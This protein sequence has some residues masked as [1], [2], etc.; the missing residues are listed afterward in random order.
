MAKQLIT[1]FLL[2]CSWVTPAQAQNESVIEIGKNLK[3]GMPLKDTIALLGIPNSL[4]VIRGT[5]SNT[6]SVVIEYPEQGLV[7]YAL[8]KGAMI[9]GI[10]VLPVFKG[11][12][13]SGVKIGD[14]F[15][16]L[17]EKYGAPQS[18]VMGTARYPD[19]S[20]YF[21]LK[22]D[23]ILSAK[24]FMKGSKLLDSRLAATAPN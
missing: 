7:I 21:N 23:V 1:I 18:L 14:K 15:P 19:L 13:A 22:D 10:E 24:V 16:T 6:D 4:R 11:R 8:S 3:V 12:F 2:L 9:E 20:L 17:V 5:D